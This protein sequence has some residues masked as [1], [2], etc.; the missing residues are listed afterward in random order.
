MIAS[1]TLKAAFS[2]FALVVALSFLS[3]CSAPDPASSE[4]TG[5][6]VPSESTGS[7]DLSDSI[8]SLPGYERLVEDME[9]G[10]IPQS[11][12]VLYDQSG[13]RPDVDFTDEETIRQIYAGL[14]RIEAVGETDMSVT[15]CYHH[16]IFTLQDGTQ[17]Q[18]A[19][20][21]EEILDCGG[22]RRYYVTGGGELWSLVRD[23]QDAQ[24]GILSEEQ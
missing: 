7:G 14:C 18:F 24:M 9:A 2:G 15:D 8:V 13:S 17:V 20:E 23:L 16:V 21:S 10:L 6:G 12:N 5:S 11:A 3:S 19:F 1:K 4:P 22:S